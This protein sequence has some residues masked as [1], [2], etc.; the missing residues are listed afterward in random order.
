M[1][2]GQQTCCTLASVGDRAV[3]NHALGATALST[4][5]ESLNCTAE[6]AEGSVLLLVLAAVTHHL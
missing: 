6:V 4:L 2:T 5:R 3:C 1:Y